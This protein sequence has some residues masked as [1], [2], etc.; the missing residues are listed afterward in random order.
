MGYS[1]PVEDSLFLSPKSGVFP[2][3][4]AVSELVTSPTGFGPV[5]SP[6]SYGS[7]SGADTK[8]IVHVPKSIT[9][10]KNLRRDLEDVRQRIA[11]SE[12][13]IKTINGNL[14]KSTTPGSSLITSRDNEQ[15]RILLLNQELASKEEDL[16]SFLSNPTT[17]TLGEIQT[18]S[19][20]IFRDKAPVRTLGSV[21]PKSF[22][23]GSRT[24]SGTM[25][26]TIFY[27]HSLH[28]LLYNNFKFYSTGT[29]DYDKQ[30]YTSI[31][32]DQLPPLN[33]SIVFANEYGAASH[34]G[35]YGVE[36]F[37]EGATHS[38]EDIYS[39]NTINYVARDLDPM[40]L[41]QTAKRENNKITNEWTKTASQLMADTEDEFGH[42]KRRN[43]FI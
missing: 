43:P 16:D 33:I 40:K 19:W 9:V 3:E 10:E 7:F 32:I 18:L 26:F 24:I 30:Q 23:R 27:Q 37:Q 42:L 36:F 25:I 6:I 41:V 38:I 8:V 12:S 29:A 15:Q 31:L 28:E 2:D 35:L 17:I 22:V 1:K 5:G 11:N 21:Y 34:M 39:E 13:R 20:S 14:A 4:N